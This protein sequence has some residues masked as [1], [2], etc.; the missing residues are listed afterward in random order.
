MLYLLFANAKAEDLR[1]EA[2]R[3]RDRRDAREARHPRKG[4]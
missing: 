3:S 2:A 1:R 4:H